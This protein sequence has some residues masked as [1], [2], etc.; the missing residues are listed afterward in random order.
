V[1]LDAPRFVAGSPQEE[2]R[3]EPLVP[4]TGTIYGGWVKVNSGDVA[5]GISLLRSGPAAYSATGAAAWAP[6]FILASWPERVRLQ[7]K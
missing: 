6:F 2:R 3:F 5:E 4:L 7:G 1:T